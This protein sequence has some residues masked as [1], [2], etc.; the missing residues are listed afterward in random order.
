[1]Y[2]NIAAGRHGAMIVRHALVRQLLLAAV[3]SSWA[4]CAQAQAPPPLTGPGVVPPGKLGSDW[5]EECLPTYALAAVDDISVVQCG[6][7]G[8]KYQICGEKS[9]QRTQL[10]DEMDPC[11]C[12]K[13]CLADPT[14]DGMIPCTQLCLTPLSDTVHSSPYVSVNEPVWRCVAV[15]SYQEDSDNKARAPGK[16]VNTR[17]FLYKTCVVGDYTANKNSWWCVLAPLPH[18]DILSVHCMTHPS[19]LGCRLSNW[20]FSVSVSAWRLARSA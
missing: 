1:V 11:E 6:D 16:W 3:R 2:Y 19:G 18:I 17:C 15:M 5:G 4:C 10:A 8:H 13:R 14:C 12:A 7:K 9:T 20:V